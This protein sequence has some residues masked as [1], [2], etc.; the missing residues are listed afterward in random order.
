MMKSLKAIPAALVAL[1][2]ALPAAQAQTQTQN[3]GQ[4]IR[5]Q[6]FSA[7]EK[8]LIRDHYGVD[9]AQ[10]P[11]DDSA[12]EWAVKDGGDDAEAD[13][14]DDDNG[15]TKD[16]ANKGK[17]KARGN[18][19]S[20]QMPPGLAKRD[21]LP[22][23]LA[24]QLKEKGRLPPGIA[25]RDLPADLAGKLP[26]RDPSQEVT[27]VDDDV[28]LVDKATGVILDVIKD[29]VTN[30]G[31]GKA[32][33]PDGTLAAPGPQS[34]DGGSEDNLLDTVLKSIFGGRGQ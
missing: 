25:K 1:M 4:V 19:K 21:E 17:D 8:R 27:V 34:Q 28:V 22:P 23:G 3:A 16:K 12:P 26:A 32:T 13:E 15:P 5:D 29:V 31:A 20:K 10:Q 14:A 6:V 24:K 7:V 30:G 9:A 33:N 18:G 2:I 11:S